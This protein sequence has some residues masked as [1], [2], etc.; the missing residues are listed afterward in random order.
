MPESLGISITNQVIKY[1]K[2]T[3]NNNQL[4]VTSFGIKFYDDLERNINQIISETNS[5]NIPICINTKD[6]KVDYFSVFGLLNKNDTR[7][8]INTEFETLCSDNHLNPNAYE[9][10]YII[11]N[12]ILN[13]DRNKVIYIWK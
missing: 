4:D 6:E 1:A 12:D 8:T 9:G 5:T 13:K 2:V 3:K 10:K 11:V 7:K